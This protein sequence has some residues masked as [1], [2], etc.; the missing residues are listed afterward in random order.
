MTL[1]I[2][3]LFLSLTLVGGEAGAV[4]AALAGSL[5]SFGTAISTASALQSCSGLQAVAEIDPSILDGVRRHRF[6]ARRFEPAH[7][8]GPNGHRACRA[9]QTRGMMARPTSCS[10]RW[11]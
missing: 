5:M 1:S 11:I 6:Q 7:D 10:S 9:S 2:Q 8:V 4:Q 3:A